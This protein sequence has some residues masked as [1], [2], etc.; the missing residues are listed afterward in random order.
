MYKLH[1]GDTIT[2]IKEKYPE[3]ITGGTTVGEV[4]VWVQEAVDAYNSRTVL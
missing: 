1:D 4:P 3:T 2:T